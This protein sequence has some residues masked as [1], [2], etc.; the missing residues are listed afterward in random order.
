MIHITKVI[1]LFISLIISIPTMAQHGK[2]LFVMSEADT[3]LLKNGKKKRQ[4]GIFLNEFYQAY[5]AIVD[6]GYSVDFATPTGKKATID[7]ESLADDYWKEDIQMKQ[8]AIDF[9]SNNQEF[10]NPMTLDKAIEKEKE[11]IGLVIPGGQGL[12]VD[13][14]YDKNTPLLLKSFA[15]NQKVIGLICHAPSFITTIQKEENPFIGY[16]VNSV[17]G[18]EEFYIEKFIMK[19]KPQK[20][21]I[22]K[23]LHKLGLEYKKG[24]PGKSYAVRDRNLITSQNPYSG[25][26]FNELYL[27]A[28]EEVN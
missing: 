23:Q 18:F 1:I 14:I 2:V 6:K 24:G 20:R 17:T 7:Q 9:W 27:K 13:L 12:M 16:K 26:Q 25:T 28:L 19:G 11:Y 10:S 4:T 22:A 5:K 3:L 15:K 8:E 21:K